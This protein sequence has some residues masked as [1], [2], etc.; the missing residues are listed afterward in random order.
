MDMTFFHLATKATRSPAFSVGTL[1][2]HVGSTPLL[3]LTRLT[4]GLAPGVEVHVKAEWTNPSGS[5]KDRPAA[6][7][8]RHALE[9]GALA[10]GRRLLDSSSGNM[11]IAY[12]AL[13]ASLGVGVHLMVPANASA[14]RLLLLRALGAE[15]TLTDPLEGTEGARREAALLAERSP[16]LYYF[17]DQYSNPA[18]W[19]SHYATTGPEILNQTQRRVTHFVAGL[20]T[21]GTM[22]GVGRFLRE[23]LPK[24]TLV[25]VQPDQPLHGLEGLKHL[26]S[27][28]HPAIFDP[29]L[30]DQTIEVGTEEAHRM[31]RQL[32]REEGLLVGFSAA[33]AVCAALAV[34]RQIE[35]GVVVA[36]LPDSAAKYLSDPVWRGA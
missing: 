33:A 31:A 34:A 8:L 5:V 15:V 10:G 3:R 23:A 29:T 32:A 19:R 30:P 25:A 24:V 6:A 18:N 1:L 16:H 11:G 27:T 28:P 21:T 13:G 12:A 17:A 4:A 36:L 2:P 22:M 14:E 20:G 26:A 35:R 7:I 9:S